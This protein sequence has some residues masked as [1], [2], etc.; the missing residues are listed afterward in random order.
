MKVQLISENTLKKYTLINDNVDACYIAPAIQMAQDMGLQ[1]LIGTVLLDKLCQLVSTDK[2]N[3]KANANY[4]ILLD[5]Y[6]TPYLCHKVMVDIQVPLFA[7]IRNA[8]IV[9]SQDTQTQQLTKSDV[10]YIRQHYDYIST[11]Y[12]NR[13]TDYLRANSTKYPEWLTRRDVADVKA[14]PESYNTTL[15]L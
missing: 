2:I 9:Q 6:I 7:K 5:E 10:D 11:F 3:E 13:M 8:G 15:V 1:P 4:K 14:D 12:G